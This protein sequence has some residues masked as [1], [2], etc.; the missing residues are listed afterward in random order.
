MTEDV[1]A[2]TSPA[3]QRVRAAIVEAA[4]TVLSRDEHASMQAVAEAAGVGRATLYRHFPSRETLLCALADAAVTGAG[5]SLQRANLDAVP[6]DEA[7]ARATRALLG[8]AEHYAVVSRTGLEVDP[9]ARQRVFIGPLTALVARGQEDGVLRDDL[10]ASLMYDCWIGMVVRIVPN[11]EAVG[12]EDAS[13][14]I[15]RLFLDGARPRS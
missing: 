2:R 12:V 6:A 8:N 5:E 13:S 9:A 7:I 3:V 4:A 15:V 11:V 10:P 1:N 14:A